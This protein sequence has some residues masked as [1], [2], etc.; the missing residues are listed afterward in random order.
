MESDKV[1]QNLTQHESD[2]LNDLVGN[3]YAEGTG[4]LKTTLKL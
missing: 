4:N 2:Y 3:S 1:A